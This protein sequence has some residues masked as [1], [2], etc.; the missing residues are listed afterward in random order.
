MEDGGWYGVS[1]RLTQVRAVERDTCDP[2][3]ASSFGMSP[4]LPSVQTAHTRTQLHSTTEAM[5]FRVPVL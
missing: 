1:L 3:V 5:H 4:S 2:G